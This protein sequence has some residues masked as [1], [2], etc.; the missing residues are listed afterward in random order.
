MSVL[1]IRVDNDPILRKKSKDIT[2]FDQRLKT[3]IQDMKETMIDAKGVG[4]SAVQVGKLRNLFIYD[5]LDGKGIRV[6]INP[7]IEF[8]EGAAIDSE[9]CLSLPEVT[10]FVERPDH[11]KGRALD[12]NGNEY[13]FEAFGFE[14]RVIQHEYDHLQ[15]S[16]IIDK[17][18]DE[19]E[20]KYL[21]EEGTWVW[22]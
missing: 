14:S 1:N 12:E 2:D 21:R 13:E 5:A 16:L 7:V 15:G 18:I 8:S 19:D 11:I 3:L 6:M 17:S 10:C 22:K 4:L 9:G 20:L